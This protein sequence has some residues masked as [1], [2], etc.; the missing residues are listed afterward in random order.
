MKI[1]THKKSRKLIHLK[2]TDKWIEWQFPASFSSLTNQWSPLPILCFCPCS[3]CLL[4]VLSRSTAHSSFVDVL[5][6]MAWS[7]VFGYFVVFFWLSDTS[8]NHF[9]LAFLLLYHWHYDSVLGALTVTWIIIDCP[10]YS[11]L[12]LL[13]D[14]FTCFINKPLPFSETD[15]PVSD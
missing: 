14:V 6:T 8:H 2:F 9:I 7:M 13:S 10:H 15:P 5:L 12:L 11:G 4:P 1:N 3:H